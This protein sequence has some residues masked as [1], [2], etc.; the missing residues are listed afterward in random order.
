MLAPVKNEYKLGRKM[1]Y[2]VC[3][4]ICGIGATAMLDLWNLLRRSWFGIA[5]PD[6]G[7]VGR[8]FACMPGQFYHESIRKSPPVK[9]ESLVGWFAHYLTGIAFAA[10]LI[11]IWGLAWIQNPTIGPALIVG[12]GSVVAPFLLM[13]PG[14]GAGIA[15]SRT[16]QP[17]HARSQSLITH[18]VFG[19]GLYL[20]G[21]VAQMLYSI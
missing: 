10:I 6:Y 5:L 12:I 4:L 21:R 3:I 2:L 17:W 13:Q 20:S 15:A 9:A 19:I 11:G 8:W 7:L 1:S 18:A 14:M 16:S